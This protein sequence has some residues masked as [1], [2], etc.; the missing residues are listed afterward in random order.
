MS[1]RDPL[2]EATLPAHKQIRDGEFD[3]FADLEEFRKDLYSASN[4]VQQ[5]QK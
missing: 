3:E 4:Q 5:S 1:L 2:D